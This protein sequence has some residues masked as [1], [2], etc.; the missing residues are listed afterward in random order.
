MKLQQQN[1]SRSSQEPDPQREERDWLRRFLAGESKLFDR[2][3]RRWTPLIQGTVA[4]RLYAGGGRQRGELLEVMQYV[5]LKICER[6][7]RALRLFR[8]EERGLHLHAYIRRIA[9]S[10]CLDWLR[11]HKHNQKIVLEP[12]LLDGVPQHN[13]GVEAQVIAK[14]EVHKLSGWLRDKLSNRG[15][16]RFVSL[17]VLGRSAKEEAQRSGDSEV[18]INSAKRDIRR[19][20]KKHREMMEEQDGQ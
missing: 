5:W 4:R 13:S 2:L 15:Y 20:A 3:Y 11:S 7:Y 1:I 18:A 6:N 19:A 9:A 16:Q 8:P 10:K 17:V 14:Q 12:Q